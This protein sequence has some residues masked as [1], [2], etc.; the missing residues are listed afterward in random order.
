MEMGKGKAE[1]LEDDAQVVCDMDRL[2]MRIGL[3]MVHLLGLP[4]WMKIMDL[5]DCRW[6]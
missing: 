5:R 3:N 2:N 1:T 6:P 4:V